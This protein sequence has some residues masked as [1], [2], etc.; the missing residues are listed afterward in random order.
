[1]A[2][3]EQYL[4]LGDSYLPSFERIKKGRSA[5]DDQEAR[6]HSPHLVVRR[7]GASVLPIPK[8]ELEWP[9]FRKMISGWNESIQRSALEM[10]ITNNGPM[11]VVMGIKN[12]LGLIRDGNQVRSEIS[13]SILIDAYGT[14]FERLACYWLKIT[15]R[16]PRKV[17]DVGSAQ[18]VARAISRK[19]GTHILPDGFIIKN[20]DNLPLLEAA[21]EYKT[22]PNESRSNEGLHR[23]IDGLVNFFTREGGK[24]L[25]AGE[26]NKFLLDRRDRWAVKEIQIASQPSIILVIPQDRDYESPNEFVKV[27]K[28]PFLMYELGRVVSTL[29][30]DIDKNGLIKHELAL[31]EERRSQQGL[32]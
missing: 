16:E 32:L 13:S 29:L 14:T 19:T 6:V 23:Q 21:C 11:A 22:N 20:N 24:T 7:A 8:L 30:D 2:S 1:M 15:T 5:W 3:R 28:A 10:F 18:R 17:L 27:Q 9:N 26:R 31:F 4:E 25:Q 12:E